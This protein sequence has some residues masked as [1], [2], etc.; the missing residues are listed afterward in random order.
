M[1]K[2]LKILNEYETDEILELFEKKVA[3]ENLSIII[4]KEKQPA[5]FSSLKKDYEKL[6][7]KYQKWWERLAME[8]GWQKDILYIN[9]STREVIQTD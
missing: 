9:F 6:I 7:H 3:M 1:E 2:T 5:L 8:N 4:D